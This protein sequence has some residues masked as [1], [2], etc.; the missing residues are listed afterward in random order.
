MTYPAI[1]GVDVD[2]FEPPLTWAGTIRRWLWRAFVALVVVLAIGGGLWGTYALLP[3]LRCGG[4]RSGVT[5]VEGQCVGVSDGSF[6]YDPPLA[7]PR[8]KAEF[9][10]VQKKILAENERVRTQ[11]PNRLDANHLPYVRVAVLMPMTTDR[12]SA[13]SVDQVRA[14]LQ[15]AY[16]AQYR[17]NNEADAGDPT[18][19]IEL[20]LANEGSNQEHWRRV[21]DQL[22]A[23]TG[24]DHPLVAVVGLGVSFPETKLAAEELGKHHVATVGAVLTADSMSSDEN[25]DGS[26]PGLTF[27]RVSP[28]NTDY[29]QKLSRYLD[30][31]GGTHR[32]MVV[33]DENEDEYTT[34]LRIAYE[35]HLKKHL[36]KPYH[37]QP[38]KGRRNPSAPVPHFDTIVGNICDAQSDAVFYA[39]RVIELKT[40]IGQLASHTCAR[41]RS[42]TIYLGNNDLS[43][44]EDPDTLNKLKSGKIGVLYVTPTDAA[45]WQTNPSDT[46][47]AGQPEGYRSFLTT[48]RAQFPSPGSGNP[49]PPRGYAIMHHDAVLVATKA[50]R[51]AAEEW[52][53]SAPTP[54]HVS[55]ELGRLNNKYAV[56]GASGTLSFSPTTR[57]WPS[58]EATQLPIRSIPPGAL[59]SS[60]TT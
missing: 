30:Q 13:L 22:V 60:P 45:H 43:S 52:G 51:R 24:G 48:F 34:T 36:I 4:L 58:R 50:I 3:D 33:Y 40:F 59:P 21:V 38:F 57:G 49:P 56:E 10:D 20:L 14:S 31:H 25:P 8:Q 12:R 29:V 53:E 42:L 35:K 6:T 17:V 2:V 54:E 37:P 11:A 47:K 44:L 5:Q 32:A 28:S 15:G 39:G 16:A 18:P 55:D 9:I 41:R 26:N 23:L 19:Q 7:A 27:V 1:A 46:R